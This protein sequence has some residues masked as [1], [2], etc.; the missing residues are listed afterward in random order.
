MNNIKTWVQGETLAKNYLI[1]NGYKIVDLNFKNKLGE[2]D[3]IAIDPQIRQQENL[4]KKVK[5]GEIEEGLA[6]RLNAM[7]EDV[8]VFVEVKARENEFLWNPLFAVNKQKQ[9]KII[10]TAKSYIKFKNLQEFQAR[11]DV[12]AVSDNKIT[13]IENAF[14]V[15]E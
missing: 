14:Q 5:N 7:C 6:R 9:N 11:F 4:K 10:K 15:N 12:I 3:I 8:L 1:E 13:H 2:I